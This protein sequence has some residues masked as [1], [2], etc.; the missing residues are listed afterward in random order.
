MVFE[1]SLRTVLAVLTSLVV[2]NFWS[3]ELTLEVLF[4]DHFGLRILDTLSSLKYLLK[5]IREQFQIQHTLIIFYM[6][7]YM[8]KFTGFGIL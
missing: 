1:F 6:M 5:R 2:F 8:E 7:E 4:L 3:Q